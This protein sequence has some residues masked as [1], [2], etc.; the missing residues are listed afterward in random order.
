MCAIVQQEWIGG[1]GGHLRPVCRMSETDTLNSC[2]GAVIEAV[3]T[4]LSTSGLLKDSHSRLP[5]AA[6]VVMSP[7]MWKVTSAATPTAAVSSAAASVAYTRTRCF[8]TRGSLRWTMHGIKQTGGT[9]WAR[10]QKLTAGERRC[11]TAA[12]A[13]AA[14]GSDCMLPTPHG[15]HVTELQ[16]TSGV[17]MGKMPPRQSIVQVSHAVCLLTRD[18]SAQHCEVPWRSLRGRL[19]VCSTVMMTQI[20]M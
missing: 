8:C 17:H 12:A 3:H 11:S 19:R 15:S 7:P 14:A 16:Q 20:M 6:S 5:N 18:S 13:V 9:S 2:R 1:G 4:W 10:K